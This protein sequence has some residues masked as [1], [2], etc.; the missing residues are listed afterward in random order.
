MTK[1]FNS[2][3]VIARTEHVVPME[4]HALL[5]LI[6]A[7]PILV[8]RVQN[9]NVKVGESIHI[10]QLKTHF[11]MK[12]FR[13]YY[14]VAALLFVC[15]ATSCNNYLPEN[16]ATTI[17][18]M[19]HSTSGN[20][21]S[22]ILSL[23]GFTVLETSDNTSLRSVSE[24]Y[25]KNGKVIVLDN[26][27]DFQDIW[28]FDEATGK[29]LQKIGHQSRNDADGYEGLNDLALNPSSDEIVGLVAGK[30]AFMHYDQN[31]NL[32]K[33]LPNGV[34]GDE[35]EMLANGGYLVYNEYGASD[36]SGL[37]F[38]LFYDKE[39]NLLKRTLSYPE[40]CDG[41]SYDGVGFLSRSD[42]TIWFN[43]PFCDTVFEIEGFK[44]IP[45]YQFDFGQSSIPEQLRWRKLTGWDVDEYSYLKEGFVKLGRFVVVQYFDK[46]RLKIGIFDEQTGKFLSLY[47]AEKD[48]LYELA[49]VGKIFSK[50]NSSFAL[51]LEPRRI[52]YLF[53]K[54]LLD[55][56]ELAKHHPELLAAVKNNASS[57]NPI[58]LYFSFKPGASI[59]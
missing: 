30:M 31:G 32:Q 58:M 26:Q 24:V 47:E 15:A 10:F 54:K 6:R 41:N 38:L 19:S 51:V 7:S 43:P 21:L 1:K 28:A 20:K 23:D 3:F 59:E 42:G 40:R 37:N 25:F 33:T 2:N 16:G 9:K 4:A 12:P 14:G 34:Y 39:G 48:F 57:N 27:T 18:P 50:E 46:Q 52:R 5:G 22:D 13:F 56:T 55:E 29:F 49:Q 8:P 53:N 44:A 36:I 35:I 45:R 17:V 11:K